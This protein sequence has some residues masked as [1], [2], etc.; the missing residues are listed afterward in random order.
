MPALRLPVARLALRWPHSSFGHLHM[1]ILGE[2]KGRALVIIGISDDS[3]LTA[4][5]KYHT[6]RRLGEHTVDPM[7]AD[8]DCADFRSWK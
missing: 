1:A 6:T 5:S 8:A 2:S 4:S 7:N 3:V